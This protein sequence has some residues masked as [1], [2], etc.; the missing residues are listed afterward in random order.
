MSSHSCRLF[1]ESEEEEEGIS[2]VR[3]NENQD[4]SHSLDS[5]RSV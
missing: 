2:K 5:V 1:S 4:G 3:E